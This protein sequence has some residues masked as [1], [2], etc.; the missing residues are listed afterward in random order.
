[1]LTLAVS[2]GFHRF[3]GS[4]PQDRPHLRHESQ[5][6]GPWVP[7]HAFVWPAYRVRGSHKPFVPFCSLLEGLT[8]LRDTVSYSCWCV[9]RDRMKDTDE[10]TD[11][12]M[13]KTRSRRVL[14]A[15]AS[16][17]VELGLHHPPSTEICSPAG[18]SSN[19]VEQDFFWRLHEVSGH[20]WLNQQPFG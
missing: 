19:L 14:S 15:G 13:H 2:I 4:D 9:I 17:P 3:K 1:M 8:K 7:T 6:M 12:E 5:V 11:G 10:Q 16:V 18:S 20:N